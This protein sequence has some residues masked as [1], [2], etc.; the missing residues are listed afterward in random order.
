MGYS[1]ILGGI[2]GGLGSI[3]GYNLG[4]YDRN[5][6]TEQDQEATDVFRKLH[7]EI[8]AQ[9]AAAERQGESAFNHTA[10]D[11]TGRAGQLDA[12][13]ALRQRYQSGGLDSQAQ[14]DIANLNAQQSE[15]A[16]A[17]RGAVANHA[18]QHG[19]GSSGA[20]LAAMRGA[21][22]SAANTSAM[23]GMQALAM[24]QNR[25]D[26]ALGAFGQMS[27]NLRGQDYGQAAD[28]AGA[29]DAI[30]RFNAMNMTNNNQ[31]N[32][33]QRQNAQQQTFSNSYGQAR[34]VSGGLN[35]QADQHRASAQGMQQ[36][37]AGHGQGLGAMTGAG[38]EMAQS[39]ATGGLGGAV[40]GGAGLVK[41][42]QYGMNADGT[43]KI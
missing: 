14:A 23:G 11:G 17:Q 1:D 28:K 26:G 31:F 36:M 21:G 19:L 33:S 8:A 9:E 15:M 12:L 24:G 42:G 4:E 13:A 43:G 38:L 30:S 27:N 37:M 20:S 6:A 39:G 25:A 22:Q 41:M 34:G 18:A 10:V 16:A 40:G 3:V 5:K 35:R 7:P 29:N 2:G 32:A